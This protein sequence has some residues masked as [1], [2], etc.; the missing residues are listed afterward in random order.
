MNAK[1]A[2]VSSQKDKLH[3]LPNSS[4]YSLIFVAFI[5]QFIHLPTQIVT[6][7]EMAASGQDGKLTTDNVTGAAAA[8]A[9]A[10]APAHQSASATETTADRIDRQLRLRQEMMSAEGKNHDEDR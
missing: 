9:V 4:S 7:R 6:T 1:K 10:A 3:F 5:H 2:F 8:A